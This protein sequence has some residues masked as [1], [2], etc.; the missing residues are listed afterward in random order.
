MVSQILGQGSTS[1]ARLTQK[2]AISWLL[3]MSSL[4]HL[5]LQYK[6]DTPPMKNISETIMVQQHID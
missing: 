1:T 6:L 2:E 5:L 4:G 3:I